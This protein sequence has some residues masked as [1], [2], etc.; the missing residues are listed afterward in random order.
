[1][2]CGVVTAISVPV[3]DALSHGD[4]VRKRKSSKACAR[5]RAFCVAGWSTAERWTLNAHFCAS[6]KVP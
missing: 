3:H 6:V 4:E 5:Q 2:P 1:M